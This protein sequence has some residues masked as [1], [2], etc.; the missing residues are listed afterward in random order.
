MLPNIPYYTRKP[1]PG[2]VIW[3]KMS[4]V[5]RYCEEPLSRAYKSRKLIDNLNNKNKPVIL[6]PNLR[7][8]NGPKS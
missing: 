4:T 1:P 6:T 3:P 8:R 7:K 5:L 2:A